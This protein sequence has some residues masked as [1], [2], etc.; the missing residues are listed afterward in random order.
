[1]LQA[2]IPH[3]PGVAETLV[4]EHLAAIEH[5]VHPTNSVK[6]DDEDLAVLAHKIDV[7]LHLMIAH[8]AH[9]EMIE[10][11]LDR[12]QAF[13]TTWCAQA[14]GLRESL[15]FEMEKTFYNHNLFVDVPIISE[16]QIAA[17]QTLREMSQEA[18]LEVVKSGKTEKVGLVD[19]KN[20]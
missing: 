3:A 4:M 2:M 15:Y 12:M 10:A 17:L 14:A 11:W 5:A 13:I 7:L 9:S 18:I 20:E 19:S 1:M 16:E 8:G 6:D